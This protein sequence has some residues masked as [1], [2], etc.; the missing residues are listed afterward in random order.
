[1]WD[2]PQDGL[3]RRADTCA[4]DPCVAIDGSGSSTSYTVVP[5]YQANG[6]TS[7][8]AVSCLI[9]P[10]APSGPQLPTTGSTSG[11]LI[12]AAMAALVFGA[13]L[14]A[15]ARRRPEGAVS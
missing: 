13:I 15:V 9:T 3:A 11:P 14:A 7:A 4:I 1:M 5:W 2:C 12:A 10:P 8:Y 6:Y